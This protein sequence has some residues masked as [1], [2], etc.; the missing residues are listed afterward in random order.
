MS[1]QTEE[2]KFAD[3]AT[4]KDAERLAKHFAE[5]DATPVTITIDQFR[6]YAPLFQKGANLSDEERMSLTDQ[7][8]PLVNWGYRGVQIVDKVGEDAT[9]ILRL[10]RLFTS[11]ATPY[12]H[13]HGMLA[14]VHAKADQNEQRRDVAVR[15][16]GDYV[17]NFLSNQTEDRVID[18]IADATRETDQI[19]KEFAQLTGTADPIPS[20]PQ[21]PVS[22]PDDADWQLDE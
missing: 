18:A 8:L 5:Q 3:P 14:A 12:T 9:V 10:P 22:A 7:Y 1:E 6:K 16:F 4:L 2:N 20:M 11:T 21:V 13:E 15:A 19:L 17:N